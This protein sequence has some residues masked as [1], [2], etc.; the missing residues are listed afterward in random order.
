LKSEEIL[1]C[2][3]IC[4]NFCFPFLETK[5]IVSNFE[6]IGVFIMIAR[7]QMI[8]LLSTIFI[9]T[10]FGSHIPKILE[11]RVGD[12]LLMSLN[13]YTCTYIEDEEETNFSHSAVV[14]KSDALGVWVA[15]ALGPKV[16]V[17]K[18]QDFT[19]HA[20]PGSDGIFQDS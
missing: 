17:K 12:V 8:T 13:C 2:E 14:I 20:R 11:L 9:S 5:I 16:H 3:E 15:Q 1:T 6:A 7:I 4:F 19:K 18:F 10:A